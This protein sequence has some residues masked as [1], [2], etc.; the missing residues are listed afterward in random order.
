MDIT[1]LVS[2]VIEIIVTLFVLGF[3]PMIKAN[4]DTKDALAWIDIAV[5][6]AEQL[7]KQTDGEKKKAYVLAFLL[8]R[9]IILNDEEL[10]TAIE[11]A[12]LRLHKE[13]SE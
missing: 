10:E 7:Y 12:V 3:V 5:R 4:M 9:N 8:N 13:L 2:L 6:A 1:N 11:A